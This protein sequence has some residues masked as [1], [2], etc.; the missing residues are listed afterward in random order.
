LIISRLCKRVNDIIPDLTTL[1]DLT[2]KRGKKVFLDDNQND[3]AD[4]I[5]SAYSVR[6]FK[7]PTV[8]TPLE[9][10]ELA[11][12]LYPSDFNIHSVR[13]RLEKKGDIWK[14]MF[15]AKVINANTTT[16]LKFRNL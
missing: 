9:W 14:W 6:P 4:T 8:S 11:T 10:K 12:N 5:A 1:E 15:S 3:E 7:I 16:V 13:Q 2:S